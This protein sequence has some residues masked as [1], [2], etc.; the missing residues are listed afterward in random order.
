MKTKPILFL[1]LLIA[2]LFHARG[3]ENSDK[4]LLAYL[5]K[6][7]ASP[8]EYV[9]EQFRV[10][11]VVLLGEIHRV[12]QNLEFVQGLIPALYA[13]GIYTIGMEFGAEEDQQRLDSLLSAP[14]YSEE[15]AQEIMFNYNVAWAFQEYIDM[16]KAAW[17]FNRTLGSGK[18]PF[19]ILNLSYRYHWENF[20]PPRTP[21]K[22]KK[23]FHRG[24]AD[25]FRTRFIG[26]EI[27]RKDEKLLALLGVY[28]AFTRYALPELRYNSNDFCTYDDQWLGNRLYRKYPGK[29][30]NILLHQAFY[31]MP[32]ESPGLL[33]PAGGRLEKL[34]E[35]NNNR[36][37]GFDL[38]NSP[39]GKLRD[40]SQFSMCYEDFNLEMLFDGYLFLA[41]LA[42]LKG[43]TVIAGFVN[44]ENIDEAL[45]NFPDPG[46]HGDINSLHEMQEFIR[47]E[48]NQLE[49]EYQR[50]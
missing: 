24:T 3:Q 33:S 23:V 15:V 38:L 20:D 31:N 14:A 41:P 42:K 39:M 19:R 47:K 48:A 40:H 21:E 29:V 35:M 11:D 50:F 18:R 10:H 45:R 28:H 2:V 37:L 44:E 4:A 12:K 13:N 9:I 26:K 30:C 6:E 34:M 8:S 7:G 32:G 16:Y 17:E 27:I 25:Q 22:L 1:I 46:W 49:K 36:P 5:E 43:C